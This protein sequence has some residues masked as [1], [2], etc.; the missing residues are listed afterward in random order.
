MKNKSWENLN[1]ESRR[2]FREEYKNQ[3]GSLTRKQALEVLFGKDNLTL[4]EEGKPKEYYKTQVFLNPEDSPSTGSVVCY[5]GEYHYDDGPDRYA[6]LEISDCHQKIRLHKCNGDSI[7]DFTTKLCLLRE[8]LDKFIIH[9]K[10]DV[11]TLPAPKE[12][13]ISIYKTAIKDIK[14]DVEGSVSYYEGFL[15]QGLLRDIFGEK[16]FSDVENLE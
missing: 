9:L 8:E 5:D 15:I 1:T 16:S 13:V 3:E 7:K 10:G 2:S 11:E 6:F 4:D 12:K 14:E